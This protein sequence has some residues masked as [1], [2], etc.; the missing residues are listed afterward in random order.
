[1][2]ADRFQIVVGA[3]PGAL[4][5]MVAMHAGYYAREHGMGEIFERKVAEG[6]SEFLLRAQRPR[7]RLWLARTVKLSYQAG[8]TR[9]TG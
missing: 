1:M 5:R 6:L 4:D 9:Q 7:N 3:I 2:N 8:Q